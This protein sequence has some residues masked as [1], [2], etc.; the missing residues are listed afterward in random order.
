M[1]IENDADAFNPFEANVN[2]P[3]REAMEKAKGGHGLLLVR[4]LMDELHYCRQHDKNIL[5]IRK[6][7]I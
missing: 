3:A 4:T 1:E 6:K 2:P 5:I 7:M